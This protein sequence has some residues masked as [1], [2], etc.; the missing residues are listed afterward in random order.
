[1]LERRDRVEV[2]PISSTLRNEVV[3]ERVVAG[4]GAEQVLQAVDVEQRR[5]VA[6]IDR[7]R[8]RPARSSAVMNE[9]AALWRRHRARAPRAGGAISVL[10]PAG[11]VAGPSPAGEPEPARWLAFA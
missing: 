5:L 9:S 1:M 10:F 11:A 8:I 7:P 4:P 3:A 2:P 6:A